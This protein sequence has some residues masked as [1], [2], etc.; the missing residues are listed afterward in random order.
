MYC[1]RSF[2]SFKMALD[3]SKFDSEGCYLFSEHESD[4]EREDGQG[5]VS[6]EEYESRNPILILA[7]EVIAVSVR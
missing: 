3:P 2:S 1:N 7:Q 6:G 4:S 5:D